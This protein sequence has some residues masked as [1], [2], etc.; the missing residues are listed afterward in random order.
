[1]D[2]G[3]NIQNELTKE[4]LRRKIKRVTQEIQEAKKKELIGDM[5]TAIYKVVAVT[6]DEDLASQMKRKKDVK[7]DSEGLREKLDML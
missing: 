2:K 6:L 3:K 4:Q 7:M 1:M 5:V